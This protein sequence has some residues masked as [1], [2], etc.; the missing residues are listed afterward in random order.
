ME[1]PSTAEDRVASEMSAWQQAGDL[2]LL[3]INSSLVI[4]LILIGH[5]PARAHQP[6]DDL[7]LRVLIA[8]VGAGTLL[9]VW[10]FPAA[11]RH[12]AKLQ[13]LCIAT[14]FFGV[15]VELMQS[16]G[17]AFETAA[18]VLAI[19]GA[20][21]LYPEVW[22]LLAIFT[23]SFLFQLGWT[24]ADGFGTAATT[25][26]VQAFAAYAIAYAF[27]FQHIRS[28]RRER[29][30][31]L[32]NEVLQDE[33]IEFLRYHD[34]ATSLPNRLRLIEWLHAS[35]QASL[36][37]LLAINVSPPVVSPFDKDAPRSEDIV[38]AVA[39]RLRGSLDADVRLFRG[40]G[41]V[42]LLW[43]TGTQIPGALDALARRSLEILAAPLPGFAGA[44]YARVAIATHAVTGEE[45]DMA[46][47]VDALEGVFSQ[48]A[49]QGSIVSLVTQEQSDARLGRLRRLQNEFEAALQHREFALYY[50]P[51]TDRGRQVVEVE[52]LV[53][54]DHP[55]LGLLPPSDFIGLIEQNGT[56]VQL[57]DWVMHESARQANE[58]AHRGLHLPIA[59]NVS[60]RQFEDESFLARLRSAI[61]EYSVDPHLLKLEVTESVAMEDVTLSSR[62][63]EACRSMGLAA[64]LDDF[65]TGYSSLA[66]LHELPFNVIKIDRSFVRLL[67]DNKACAKIVRA[68]IAL[69][70]SL[71]CEAHA[72]G[73]EEERQLRWLLAAECD[74]FQ[75]YYISAALA[76]VEF[77]R[78][79]YATQTNEST[80][81]V[82]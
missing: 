68:I 24:A 28:R 41:T 49:D 45:R 35:G 39:A 61:A 80:R 1:R 62:R 36:P 57:G 8:A 77:E 12:A 19:M 16:R 50:Q 33:Q 31:H 29:E 52:A 78:W 44:V 75:G 25:A 69:S 58:W 65:G 79:F 71:G 30:L 7:Q 38:S 10:L 20:T 63:L 48:S 27:G 46:A 81:R 34:P 70:H 67:P 66:Y 11:R 53:R 59:F 22:S 2:R 76:L 73:V 37:S 55:Q 54:W 60:C 64:A 14:L 40:R 3:V 82:L 9:A 56:I 17:M 42:L 18:L 51:V 4:P 5:W 21:L 13:A 43:L 23:L 74:K 47:V 32:R 72:E 15:N 6:A 26:L